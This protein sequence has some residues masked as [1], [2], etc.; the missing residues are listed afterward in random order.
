MGEDLGDAECK[1]DRYGDHG[2]RDQKHTRH[3]LDGLIGPLLFL[4]RFVH[5]PINA[6]RCGNGAP[7][8]GGSAASR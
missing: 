3:E 8:D 7:S 1:K 2:E 4:L 5:M 6:Q